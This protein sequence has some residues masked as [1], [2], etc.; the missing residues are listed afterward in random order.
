MSKFAEYSSEPNR[1]SRLT[2]ADGLLVR[3]SRDPDFAEVAA[4]AAEREGEAPDVWRDR[5][6]R[7]AEEI[8]AGRAALLVAELRGAVIGYGTIAFFS[9]PAGSPDNVAPEGWYLA[10]LVVRPALRRRGVGLELTLARLAWIA[11]RS[12]KAYYFANQ[13]NRAS[14]QL[15]AAAGFREL[16]RGF[17]HPRVHFSE[18]GGILFEC[19]PRQAPKE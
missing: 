6:A 9:P 4:I 18:G 5:L 12:E 13:R 2:V 11:T 8:R 15:H 19:D 16:S 14:I 10:G 3:P 1:S 7:L 17:H